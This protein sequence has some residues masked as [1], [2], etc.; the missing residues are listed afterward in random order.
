MPS[1]PNYYLQ[2]GKPAKPEIKSGRLDNKKAVVSNIIIET[3][4]SFSLYF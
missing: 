4:A 3:T 2:A 1:P